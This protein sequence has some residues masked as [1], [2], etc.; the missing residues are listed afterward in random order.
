MALFILH[1]NI[2]WYIFY[3]YML[4]KVPQAWGVEAPVRRL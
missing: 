1:K 4:K 2:T 3:L